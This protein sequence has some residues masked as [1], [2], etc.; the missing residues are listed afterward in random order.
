[1]K[2]FGTFWQISGDLIPPIMRIRI[3]ITALYIDPD[4]TI[5]FNES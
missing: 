3:H 5:N 4:K 2:V 1:M